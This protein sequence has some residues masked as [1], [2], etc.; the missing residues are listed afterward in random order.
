M[1]GHAYHKPL[2]GAHVTFIPVSTYLPCFEE[3]LGFNKKD[4]TTQKSFF[5]YA[6][7][8]DRLE[9]KYQAA[10]VLP[11]FFLCWLSRHIIILAL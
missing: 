10:T 8:S 1:R 3:R 9:K 7:E 2:S 6:H 4:V 5:D 11:S